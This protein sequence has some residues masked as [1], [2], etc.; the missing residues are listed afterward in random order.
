MLGGPAVGDIRSRCLRLADD[1]DAEAQAVKRLLAYRLSSKGAEESKK[2]WYDIVEGDHVLWNGVSDP[3]KHTIRAFLV[4]FHVNI[5]RHS[6][7]RFNFRSGSV[8][9]FFFAGARTFFRSLEAA[10]FLFS[11]VA[12]IPEGSLVLPAICT[13]ERIHL[14]A[15]LAD[16]SVIAGQNQISH[17]ALAMSPHEVNKKTWEPLPA[18]VKRVFYLSAE[19]DAQEHEVAPL[20]NQ[21]MLMELARAEAVIYGMGSLYTSIC[22]SLVLKGVGEAVAAATCPKL[23]IL[24]GGLDR[25]SSSCQ[26]HPGP[27][28]ASDVVIAIVDALNRRGA[29]SRAGVQLDKDPSEY[30]TAVIVPRGGQLEVDEAVLKEMGLDV[31]PVASVESTDGDGDVLYDPD[32]L[33]QAIADVVRRN[34]GVR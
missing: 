5:M 1:S 15:E 23:L 6:T 30:V 20:P 21:R 7:E 2:E 13:E 14:A 24:N 25:E 4:H 9:N 32:A 26:A 8:G 29:S 16:G 27:M 17:P 31:I 10:I 3:Y 11:R 34:A 18:P 28:A 12:R 22:P 33:V 19:G